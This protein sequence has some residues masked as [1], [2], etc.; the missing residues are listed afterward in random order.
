MTVRNKSMRSK[1]KVWQRQTEKLKI[2]LK[3]KSKQKNKSQ[4][5]VKSLETSL[6]EGQVPHARTDHNLLHIHQTGRIRQWENE[7]KKTLIY[8]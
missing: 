7:K 4:T 1:E 6:D 2:K 5:K 8:V 3:L